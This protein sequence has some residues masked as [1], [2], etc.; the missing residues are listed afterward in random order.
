MDYIGL[1]LPLLESVKRNNKLTVKLLIKLMNKYLGTSNVND[2]DRL[3]NN[4]LVI[5]IVEMCL[6]L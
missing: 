5:T 3:G 4:P 6:N 2:S 1:L